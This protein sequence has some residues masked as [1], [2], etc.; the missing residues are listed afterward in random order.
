MESYEKNM[1]TVKTDLEGLDTKA[2]VQ[3]I[4]TKSVAEQFTDME[5]K[6]RVQGLNLMSL[7]KEFKTLD[8]RIG[9]QSQVR[10]TR[11]DAISPIVQANYRHGAPTKISWF[12]SIGFDQT[13]RDF[14]IP[15]ATNQ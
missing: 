2:N 10:R 4:Q 14:G 12:P 7:A 11:T 15:Y 3:M 9:V 8:K 6:L 1:K 13:S 5:R